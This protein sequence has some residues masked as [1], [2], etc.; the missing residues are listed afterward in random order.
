MLQI[1]IFIETILLVKYS[2]IYIIHYMTL[3]LTNKISLSQNFIELKKNYK[4][5]NII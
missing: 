2:N 5:Y 3:L 4:I 1:K